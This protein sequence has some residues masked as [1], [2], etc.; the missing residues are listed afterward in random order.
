MSQP[1]APDDP[2]ATVVQVWAT[3]AQPRPLGAEETPAAIEPPPHL[4]KTAKTVRAKKPKKPKKPATWGFKVGILTSGLV[5]V[6]VI[7]VIIY[8]YSQ[9][10]GIFFGPAVDDTV[11]VEYGVGEEVDYVA[12]GSAQATSEIGALVP[13]WGNYYVL[14]PATATYRGQNEAFHWPVDDVLLESLSGQRYG[15][16]PEAMAYFNGLLINQGYIDYG[17]HTPVPAG[18][19]A[20]GYFIFQVP[21]D[22]ASRVNLVVGA[23]TKHPVKIRV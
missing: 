7:G 2:T 6:V 13:E 12:T 14:V 22:A 5:I 8:G 21:W 4:G 9:L 16:D 20:S 1:A 18:E 19:M 3:N 17:L 23:T 10:L 11:T 15:I